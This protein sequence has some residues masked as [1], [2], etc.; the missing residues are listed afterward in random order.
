MIG[1]AK[2]RLPAIP[3]NIPTEIADYFGSVGNVI[4]KAF[5]DL[6]I[7]LNDPQFIMVPMSSGGMRSLAEAIKEGSF[8]S[9]D[10]KPSV[11]SR[12]EVTRQA[13]WVICNGRNGTPDSFDAFVVGSA[14]VDNGG[15][16]VAGGL[17]T[18]GPSP[19]DT[20]VPVP[21]M[22][23]PGDT[24]VQVIETIV[25][26]CADNQTVLVSADDHVHGMN[27]HVHDMNDHTH[28]VAGSVKSF[29]VIWMMKL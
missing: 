20:D 1:D 24:T 15:E 21:D 26:G 23:D 16:I 22:T 2:F 27:D 11:A 29:A 19:T 8:R 10:L 6:S 14:E 17:A 5:Q 28:L 25:D 12:G 9:G 18:G 3:A 4:A 13:G 7:K